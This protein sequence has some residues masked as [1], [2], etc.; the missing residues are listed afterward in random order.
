MKIWNL[1][2]LFLIFYLGT[3]KSYAQNR[4]T[5][6]LKDVPIEQA[7]E[8]IKDN[9]GYKF[10]YEKGVIHPEWKV[11]VQVQDGSIEEVL[12]QL[13]IGKHIQYKV[14]KKQILLLRQPGSDVLPEN[15]QGSLQ[16]RKQVSGYVLDPNGDPVVGVNI[17]NANAKLGAITNSDGAF[18]IYASVSDSLA[19]SF[20]GFKTKKICVDQREQY[21]VLLEEEVANLGEIMVVSSGYQQLPKDRVTGSFETISSKQIEEVPTINVLSRLEGKVAGVDFDVK[22]NTIT[23]R[24]RNSYSGSKPLVVIDGFPMPQEDFKFNQ[25][26]TFQGAAELSYLNPDDIENI[27]ILKDAAASSIWGSRAANGVIVITTKKGNRAKEPSVNFGA[28]F[29]IGDKP[30]LDQLKQMNSAEYIDFER[31][32]IELGY[33][34][35]QSSNW[36]AKNP[37]DAQAAVF[38]HLRGESSEVEME[39]YL[40]ELGNRDN[41]SQIKKYLLRKAVSQQYN[42]SMSNATKTGNYF[43]SGNYNKDLPVMKANEGESYNI[44]YNNNTNFFDNILH[45]S[46]GINYMSS[47]YTVNNSVNEA[48]STGS[49]VGL[50]PYDMIVGEDGNAVDKY[51]L[52]SPEVIEDFEG[53]GYL[54]WTYNYLDELE[55]SNVVTKGQAIRLNAELSA[56]VTKWLKASVSGMYYKFTSKQEAMNTTDSYFVRNLFNT[57]TSYDEATGE[58]TNGIPT[59][60]YY[61]LG[62]IENENYNLR[63]QLSV[64]KSFN[65]VHSLNA[66]AVAEIRQ[67]KRMSYDKTYYGF[68]FDTSSGSTVN[69]TEYYTTVYG[70]QTYIGSYDNGISRYRNRYLSYVGT[71]SY[72]Y[73]STYF[74]SGSLRFDDYS[75]LGASRKDRA[76]PLWSAGFRWKLLNEPFIQLPGFVSHVDLRMTY[77]IGGSTPTGG[78]GNNTAVINLYDDY[79]TDLPSASISTPGNSRLK[80]ETT[81]TF[82][83]GIDYGIFND[84]ING[85]FEYYTKRSSDILANMPFNATYGFTYLRYNVGTLSGHGVDIGLNAKVIDSQFKWSSSFTFAYN[86]NE[87]TSAYYK[88]TTVSEFLNSG[89]LKEGK[90]LGSVYTYRWAGL[91]DMGRSQIYDENGDIIGDDVYITD[92]DPKILKY[93]GTTTAPY[94]GGWTNTFSYKALVMGVQ[95]SYYL[96]HVFT[97]PVLN[98]YPSYAG[99][100]YGAIGRNKD[101]AKRWR[102]PGDEEATDIPGLPN[103][104]YN[105]YSRYNYSDINVLPAGHVRLNQVSLSYTLPESVVKKMYMKG[106]SISFVARNLGIIWRKNKD[107]Y[108][109]QYLSTAN[110]NT[111]TPSRNYMVRVSASF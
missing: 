109:P 19:F 15:Q 66:V 86:T 62:Y 105:S 47:K 53:K 103:M 7:F 18:R 28:T 71:G 63:G 104:T 40:A 87:V 6:E 74:L 84:R 78:T 8:K 44:T 75:L 25:G 17:W 70:W 88:N 111:L 67:E 38:K 9:T 35:D 69:P 83:V 99:T 36:Q 2:M 98:N 81:K 100:H 32:L 29:S 30:Y 3:Q 79:S 34:Y 14:V 41:T 90:A 61:A 45:L 59:G 27:S 58:L 16:S 65:K 68:D 85:S 107:G 23:I 108:D 43:I 51:V 80:W 33:L 20:I 55:S 48:L 106:A 82:N 60:G 57:A 4:V 12:K 64:N 49:D 72:S 102:E 10:F 39:N 52:F 56:D 5:I 96:G 31:D 37:S 42:F 93:K 1:M 73:K 110:Y 91:D 50:R 13:F 22:N 76:M 77:G 21:P 54:P 24:G 95:M 92:L 97:K 89:G 46:T 26:K 94:F 11:T 101:F